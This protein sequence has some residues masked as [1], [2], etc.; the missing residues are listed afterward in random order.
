MFYEITITSSSTYLVESN[1]RDE[2][3]E[4]ALGWF[5]ELEPTIEVRSLCPHLDSGSC[6]MSC[7]DNPCTGTEGDQ[8]ECAYR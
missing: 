7:D 3:I 1:D 4:Q 2:A 6:T 8:E 5:D